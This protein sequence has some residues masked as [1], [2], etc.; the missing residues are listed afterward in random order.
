MINDSDVI[1]VDGMDSGFFEIP[2]TPFVKGELR[3]IDRVVFR[4]LVIGCHNP[5]EAVKYMKY[6]LDKIVSELKKLDQNPIIYWRERPAI[7]KEHSAEVN[8]NNDNPDGYFMF[9]RIATQPLLPD[10]FWET[11]GIVNPD[12]CRIKLTSSLGKD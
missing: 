2:A 12:G 9:C 7:H 10:S 6:T 5:N 3:D 1:Q 8:P 4:T 11:I